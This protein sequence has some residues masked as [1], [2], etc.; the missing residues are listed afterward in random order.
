MTEADIIFEDNHLIAAIKR[1]GQ[2]VQGDITGDVPITDDLKAFLKE[3]YNK[4]G[5]V[6]LGLTHR[7]DRPVG[8]VMVFAKTGKAL[9]RM[10][11][12]FRTNHPNKQYLA[13][14][15]NKPPKQKD[16]LTHYLKKNQKQNKSYVCKSSEKDAKQSILEYEL[17]GSSDNYH[18]LVIKLLTGRHH[19]IRTQLAH[20]GCPI[21][22]DLKYG[23]DRSN[24]DGSIS[25]YAWKLQITHPV[26]KTT[27]EFRA[28]PPEEDIWPLFNEIIQNK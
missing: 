24:K 20:I 23:F 28:N 12:Q 4:P 16:R 25:L 11:E 14:V 8:G 6:F 26:K 1:A 17:I 18:L 27:L 22:G 19:Q 2:L 9:S 15:K 7:L 3:K 5:N 21:K 13:I 10:N